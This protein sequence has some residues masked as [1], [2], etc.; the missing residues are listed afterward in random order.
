MA[1]EALPPPPWTAADPAA[2]REALAQANASRK[3]PGPSF[4]EYVFDLGQALQERIF[5]AISK[6]LPWADLSIVE[7]IAL[8][9]ALGAAA[10]AALTVLVVAVRRWL[11]RRDRTR[12][13]SPLEIQP[14]PLPLGDAAWWQAELRRR[15]AAGSLRPALEAAWWW[16]ARRLDPPGLDPSWTTGELLRA[17]NAAALRGPLRRL[18]RMLWGAGAPRLDEVEAVVT[19]L[20]EVRP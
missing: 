15:L 13:V 11:A 19:D 8:Y 1:I 7:R 12:S 16:T 18:D 2:L 4:G 3:L 6:A 5:G 14:P 17:G 20:A 9:T 10:L